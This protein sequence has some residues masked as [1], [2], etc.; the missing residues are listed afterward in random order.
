MILFKS[1]GNIRK[2]LFHLREPSGKQSIDSIKIQILKIMYLY[3][4]FIT[5]KALEKILDASPYKKVFP[6]E[7]IA[8]ILNA[9]EKEGFLKTLIDINEKNTRLSCT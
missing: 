9:L 3:N 5:N 4:D 6:I 1:S 8:T 7:S 2:I